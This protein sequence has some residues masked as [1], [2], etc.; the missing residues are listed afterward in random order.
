MAVPVIVWMRR[1]LRA[2]DNALLQAA[3]GSD[4]PIVPVYIHAPE[5]E[6]PWPPGSAARWWLRQSLE[7]LARRLAQH[8]LPLVLRRGNTAAVLRE[9]AHETG[10]N[11]VYYD[12]RWEPAL[13]KRDGAVTQT[14]ARDGVAMRPVNTALLITPEELLTKQGRPYQV[15]TPFWQAAVQAF[16]VREPAGP[17]RLHIPDTVPAGEPWD[18]LFTEAPPED[19]DWGAQWTPGEKGAEA[20][21]DTFLEEAL[22]GYHRQR[23]IPGLRGTSR[24]SPHLHFGELSPHRV[25][26]AVHEYAG[27]RTEGGLARGAESWVRELYWREFGHYLLHHFPFTPEAPLR[28]QFEEFPWADD[29][30]ALEAWQRGATGYPIVDAGMRELRATGWMHNRVRMVVASFLVKDLLLPWQ[31][32]AAWFWERLVDADLGNNTLGWQWAGGCGADAAPYFRI[33]NPVLQGEK[34]DA[35]GAYVRAWIPEI[36]ALPNKRIY[37]PWTASAQEL[38]T[39]G[40]TLG[41]TYPKP[42]VDHREAR[43]RA[44]AAFEQVKGGA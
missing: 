19:S 18:R 29:P 28:R 43:E 16:P 37:K 4:A 31:Q 23:D 2:N 32:G 15:F 22:A 11:A 40:V 10:A 36:A 12:Q 3:A 39:A 38:E 6:Q 21:L 27:L 7:A 41:K 26:H 25:W 33:F 30:A 5:E 35:D 44:L 1:C 13:V 42:M 8:H 34:F 14:L 9:L 20:A 24:L 17:A